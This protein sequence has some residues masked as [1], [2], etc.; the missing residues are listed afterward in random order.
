MSFEKIKRI[1]CEEFEIDEADV[2]LDATLDE[3]LGFDE[4]DLCDLVMSIE[5]EFEKELPDE[6]LEEIFTIA[7][8]VKYLEE[9]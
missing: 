5:D 8:L 9:N 4:L 1:I 2:T 3:D 7:D 6:A